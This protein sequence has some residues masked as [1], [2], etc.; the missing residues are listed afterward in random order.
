M[1]PAPALDMRRSSEGTGE[2]PL[3][4]LTHVRKADTQVCA[5]MKFM[6]MLMENA[7]LND[8]MTRS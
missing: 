4:E 7:Q 2:A 1:A 5:V 3:L 6:H 8:K